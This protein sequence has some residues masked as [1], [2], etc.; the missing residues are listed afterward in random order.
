M[1]FKLI[2]YTRLNGEKFYNAFVKTK[3]SWSYQQLDS[4]GSISEYST[5]FSREFETRDKALSAMDEYKSNYLY[6]KGRE[7]VNTKIEYIIK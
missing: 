4:C 3:N 6:Q 7:I 1:K 5:A 2:E